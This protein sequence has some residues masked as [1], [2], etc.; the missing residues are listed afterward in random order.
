MTQDQE[1]IEQ[2]PVQQPGKRLI[3]HT[4]LVAAIVVLA[5]VAML[6]IW[7]NLR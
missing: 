1:S 2:A 3:S 7:S 5:A 4:T 6:I